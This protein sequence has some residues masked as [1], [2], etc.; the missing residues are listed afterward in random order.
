MLYDCYEA[1][2]HIVYVVS[3]MLMQ[4]Q[5]NV[6]INF[7]LFHIS[8]TPNPSAKRGAWLLLR[9]IHFHIV[10]K[11]IVKEPPPCKSLQTV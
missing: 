6:S 7:V 10:S 2:L 9:V 1:R 8:H 3:Q 5:C 11:K 4:S